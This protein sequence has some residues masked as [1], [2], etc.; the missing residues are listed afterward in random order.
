LAAKQ[1]PKYILKNARPGD[2]L[3][4]SLGK[5]AVLNHSTMVLA[6]STKSS[7]EN[8]QKYTGYIWLLEGNY[9]N[10]VVI[11]ERRVQKDKT[12]LGRLDQL[13]LESPVSA[14]IVPT[15]LYQRL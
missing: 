10:K 8:E 9:F 11:K 15:A 7:S 5:R 13:S 1:K 3:A 12:Y 2:Y 6:T 4:V 14:G